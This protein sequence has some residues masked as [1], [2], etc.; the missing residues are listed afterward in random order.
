MRGG[1]RA[2]RL[3]A[4]RL[5]LAPHLAHD[6]GRVARVGPDHK[7]PLAV[8]D[9]VYQLLAP[10]GVARVVDVVPELGLGLGL[11]VGLVPHRVL[12]AGLQRGCRRVAARGVA[13]VGDHGHEALGVLGQHV[14]EGVQLAW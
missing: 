10:Q 6:H 5:T 8:L 7:A 13:R 1:R 9:H 11:G 2:W 12:H 14:L 4:W 3:E